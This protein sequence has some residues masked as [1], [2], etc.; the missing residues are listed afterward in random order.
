[1]SSL[2][3]NRLPARFAL[4]GGGVRS[5]KSRFA[6]DLAL[7]RGRERVFIATAQA[8]DDEMRV[9]IEKHRAERA[10]QFQTLEVP[11]D[12]PH[13]IAALPDNIEVVLVDCLTLWLSNLL[14]RGDSEDQIENSVTDLVKAIASRRFHSLIVTNEVGMGIVP[15]SALGRTFRDVAGRAHQQLAGEADEIYFAALGTVL[16]LRPNPAEV[17][18]DRHRYERLLAKPI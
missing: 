3:S 5:G 1:M 15:T 14:L 12:V 13:A 9:R 4:I 10:D 8:F 7:D 2:S 16:Q 6:V 18:R 17:G 11:M